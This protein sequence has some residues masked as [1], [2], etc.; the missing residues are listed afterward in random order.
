[1]SKHGDRGRA[2]HT[3]RPANPSLQ[4]GP[5]LPSGAVSD[6]LCSTTR[7]GLRIPCG[8]GRCQ[9]ARGAPWGY[10]EGDSKPSLLLHKEWS[11]TQRQT[12]EHEVPPQPK[13]AVFSPGL[14][15]TDGV[16]LRDVDDGSEGLERSAAALPH[17]QSTGKRSGYQVPPG[18]GTG[19]G[20]SWGGGK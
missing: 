2:G 17:L 19:A 12:Q 5:V 9:A 18:L 15:S 3:V 13:C 20:G 8:E 11:H 10:T 4:S 6:K 14:E 1:M 16:D 7:T